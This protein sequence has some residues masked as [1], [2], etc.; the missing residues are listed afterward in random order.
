[1][2]QAVYTIPEYLAAEKISRT[3]VYEEWK[4]GEGVEFF[5]RGDRVLISHEARIRHREKLER[6]AREER[7]SRSAAVSASEPAGV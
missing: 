6:K 3:T 5:R 1:M 2:D 4:R 7:E